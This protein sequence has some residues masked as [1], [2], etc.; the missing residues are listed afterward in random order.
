M[1][2]VSVESAKNK[3]PWSLIKA[4]GDCVD[5]ANP[6]D[7]K[8]K[9]DG[10]LLKKKVI[11]AVE[12]IEIRQ[13]LYQEYRLIVYKNHFY[14]EKAMTGDG[15]CLFRCLA[16]NEWGCAGRHAE[17]RKIIV[18]FVLEN[19][20][21]NMQ[22]WVYFSSMEIDQNLTSPD[23]YLQ[24]MGKDGVYGQNLEIAMFGKIFGKS[25]FIHR[26]NNDGSIDVSAI[27][28]ENSSDD[29]LLSFT[30]NILGGHFNYFQKIQSEYMYPSPQY[31]SHD[32]EDDGSCLNVYTGDDANENID[33]NNDVEK[34]PS[35]ISS[36]TEHRDEHKVSLTNV[37]TSKTNSNDVTIGNKNMD[38]E[39]KWIEQ[40]PIF[41]GPDFWNKYV[42]CTSKK[43][44]NK[45]WTDPFND[46]FQKTYKCV[47]A[48][49]DN[50][51]YAQKKRNKDSYFKAIAVCKHT[52]CTPFIF[53]VAEPITPPYK[54]YRVTV[55]TYSAIDHSDGES[56]R[57]FI[58]GEN[59]EKF[60]D[61]LKAKT[62][63]VV[64]WEAL[65]EACNKEYLREGNYNNCPSSEILQKICSELRAQNDLD[66]DYY[67]FMEKLQKQ[68]RTQY[69]E[70]NAPEERVAGYIQ[71]TASDPVHVIMFSQPQLRIVSE[72]KHFLTFGCNWNN[73]KAARQFTR[74]TN[75]VLLQN[76]YTGL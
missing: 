65:N 5:K 52:S 70:Y 41:I 21:E 56:H 76:K 69:K 39:K 47:L 20:D 61:E 14:R 58:R 30:G 62:P 31:W 36:D 71:F 67:H 66:D 38:V 55:K 12:R 28:V 2:S 59:R 34:I 3:W 43:S 15:N 4:I 63:A 54:N 48:F 1:R 57:R 64:K 35:K 40:L 18:N 27:E 44:L 53:E 16:E 24:Y 51:F 29:V 33:D 26:I 11:A 60:K 45:G 74:K 75:L 10:S 72:E 6:A 37:S 17:M 50:K 49:E 22:Q 9:M 46:V 8:T 42:P 68:Y 32:D 19:W 7:L 73:N 13:Q 23:D 25:V